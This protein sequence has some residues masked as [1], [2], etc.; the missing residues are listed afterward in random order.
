MQNQTTVLHEG[1]QP[2]EATSTIQ[3][4][5][6]GYVSLQDRLAQIP[7]LALLAAGFFA[8]FPLE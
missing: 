8:T 6:T 2:Q 7:R 5:D 4:A 3:P 1:E